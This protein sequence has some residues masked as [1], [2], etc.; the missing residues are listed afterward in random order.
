MKI[1]YFALAAALAA[2]SGVAVAQSANDARCILLANAYAKQSKDPAAQKMAES[3]VYFYLGRIGSQATTAQMKA[4]F[5]QQSKTITDA[6]AG[7]LMGDCVKGVETKIEMM[8]TLAAQE[9]PTAAPA[10]K[11]P[12]N[13]QGR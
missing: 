13:P 4:L 6:N 2:T 7:G 3:S 1:R 5:D 11:K 9:A 12:A 10:T 8:Q